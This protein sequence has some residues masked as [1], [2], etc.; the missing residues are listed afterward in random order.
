[1]AMMY[2]TLY[3]NSKLPS[4]SARAITLVFFKFYNID[5]FLRLPS[6]YDVIYKSD[7]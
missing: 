2:K 1:M 7:I 5:G 4:I 6:A 3:T